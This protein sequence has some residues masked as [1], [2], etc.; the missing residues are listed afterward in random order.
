LVGSL[1]LLLVV[2]VPQPPQQVGNVLT[3]GALKGLR[4]AQ[5]Q[6]KK[7][8]MMQGDTQ[9]HQGN[10]NKHAVVLPVAARLMHPLNLCAVCFTCPE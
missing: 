8:N 5:V 4:P 6:P 10:S 3:C 7:S 2:Y 9:G 1:L